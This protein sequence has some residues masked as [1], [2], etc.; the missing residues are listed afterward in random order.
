MKLD[1]LCSDITD[2]FDMDARIHN[3]RTFHNWNKD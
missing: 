3:M 2:S 1:V